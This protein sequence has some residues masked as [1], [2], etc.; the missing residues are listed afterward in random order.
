MANLDDETNDDWKIVGERDSPNGISIPIRL[1]K[2]DVPPELLSNVPSGD[3]S[4]HM[5]SDDDTHM[6]PPEENV[7]TIES[8]ADQT[9]KQPGRSDSQNRPA[10]RRS[11]RL[12]NFE[13]THFDPENV[14][15]DRPLTAYFNL[16]DKNTSTKLI[17]DSLISIGIPA[18]AVRCLQRSPTGRVE[19]TFSS[20]RY[21]DRFLSRSSFVVNQRPVVVHP[22]HS[23]V[24]FVTVYDAPYELPDPALE[25]RLQKYGRIFSS[26]RGHLQEFPNI[27]N[28][29]RHLRMV[30][31]TPIPSYIR[32]GKYLVRV[33]YSN[34]PP[35][36][37]RCN[38][39][40][41]MARDCNQEVCFNCDSTGHVARTCPDG[42]RCCICKELGHKALDCQLSW[43]F[44]PLSERS[45][46][47]ESEVNED[48]TSCHEDDQGSEGGSDSSLSTVADADSARERALSSQGLVLETSQPAP[49][50]PLPEATSLLDDSDSQ[51]EN[52]CDEENE[53]NEEESIHSSPELFP[54]EQI[55]QP[56]RKRP[57]K[58]HEPPESG[59][60]QACMV[61]SEG[62]AAENPSIEMDQGEPT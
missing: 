43:S 41:H 14:T 2:D 39:P 9:R 50:S 52:K 3:N 35:T 49:E 44:R 55:Q 46:I 26:R 20:L 61:L 59:G 58:Q 8:Y 60:K 34:Q 24:T 57:R 27:H 11:T 40:D 21:R 18:N 54:S 1:S 31:H 62:P 16:H 38:S 32:F 15:P 17:F 42:V 37:R 30:I 47:A 53:S 12:S 29:L 36:C 45:P 6:S 10:W 13:R 19:I 23:P 28:G 7:P 56:S 5:D 33:Q 22:E 48:S 4:S 51:S 25:Y